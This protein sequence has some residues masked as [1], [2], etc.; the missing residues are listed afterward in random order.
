M[1]PI[2]LFISGRITGFINKGDINFKVIMHIL[3]QSHL[4]WTDNLPPV[5]QRDPYEF[6]MVGGDT[7]NGS[8]LAYDPEGST[9]RFSIN[10]TRATVHHGGSFV[11][12]TNVSSLGRKD[13]FEYFRISV[14]DE[15]NLQSSIVVKVGFFKVVFDLCSWM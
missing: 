2:K 6:S 1:S 12:K 3:M 11:Y 15:C 5:L 10:S 13:Y 14:M 8:I 9:L 4:L 7:I